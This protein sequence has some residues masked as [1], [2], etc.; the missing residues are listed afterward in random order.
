MLVLSLQSGLYRL[1]PYYGTTLPL[2]RAIICHCQ[3]QNDTPGVKH[4]SSFYS[5]LFT[6]SAETP[7]YTGVARGEE[8]CT[9]LHHSSPLF[10][11]VLRTEL[12]R[13]LALFG[14]GAETTFLC[15]TD[16]YRFSGWREVKSDAQLFTRAS[17]LA[18]VICAILVKSEECFWKWL[19]VYHAHRSAD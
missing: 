2:T 13:K 11:F 3:A 4:H 14:W 1:L 8:W 18:R 6:K 12:K 10:T 17:C 16:F 5:S 19:T 9:A 7:I 15:P